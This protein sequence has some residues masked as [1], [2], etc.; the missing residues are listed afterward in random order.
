VLADART[1]RLVYGCHYTD[2][3]EHRGTKIGHGN[4]DPN[5]RV[6][7]FAGRVHHSALGLDDRVHG[8]GGARFIFAAE[9]GN[10]AVHKPRIYPM[11]PAVTHSKAIQ[12][13]TAIIL[14]Q[15]IAFFH[16]VGENGTCLRMFEIQGNAE[17]IAQTID[18]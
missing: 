8:L 12:G 5:R 18:G 11:Q 3:A 17:F 15:H 6:L 4:P 2:N 14:N 7:R 16:K 9:T 1:L 13:S 10:G